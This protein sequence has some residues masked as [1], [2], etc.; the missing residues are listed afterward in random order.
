MASGRALDYQAVPCTGALLGMHHQPARQA[1]HRRPR[2]APPPR[3]PAHATL[4]LLVQPTDRVG[5]N[6]GLNVVDAGP[7]GFGGW[8]Q[9]GFADLNR[10][11]GVEYSLSRHPASGMSSEFEMAA[12]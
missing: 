2:Q 6:T 11:V 5:V 10:R 9:Q 3:Q 4:W 8:H 7:T 1:A 12:T